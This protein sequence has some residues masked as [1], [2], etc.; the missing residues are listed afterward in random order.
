[1]QLIPV[2]EISQGKCVHTEP[3]NRFANKVVSENI[4]ERVS[5]WVDGG[6]RRIHYVD[7]DAIRTR[8][9]ENISALRQ[10]KQRHPDLQ[11]QVLGGIK[12]IESAY[13][14]HEGGADN[15]VLSSRAL[16]NR[17][18]VE[19]LC[20]EFPE[21][22]WLELDTRDGSLAINGNVSTNLISLAREL[23]HDGVAGLIVT[24]IAS[25]GQSSSS[26]L[27]TINELAKSIDIPVIA[28]GGIQ[29][30]GDL[31]RLL[32]SDSSELEGVILGKPLY[33][34][35]ICLTQAR[36]MIGQYLQAS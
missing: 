20:L 36:E 12:S 5:A 13:I 16:K 33:S 26:C 11:V 28:N 35:D 25:P 2:V 23:E 30:L 29:V 31:E 8:E 17:E 24:E 27:M 34:G 1:M 32:M 9:P 4:I 18:F 19:D 6:V 22:V 7:V 3:K 14:W 15:F 10:I 21:R